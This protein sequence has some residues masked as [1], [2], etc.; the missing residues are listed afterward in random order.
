MSKQLR[1]VQKE[2]NDKVKFSLDVQFLNLILK[3]TQ[4]DYVQKSDIYKLKKFI[5]YTDPSLYTS[6]IEVSI[7]LE[8]LMNVTN[9]LIEDIQDIDLLKMRLEEK[10][11]PGVD[12]INKINLQKNMLN[13]SECNQIRKMIATRVQYIEVFQQK[14]HL[15]RLLMDIDKDYKNSTSFFDII[16]ELKTAMGQLLVALQDSDVTQGVMKEFSF[17]DE[18]AANILDNMITKA[19]KPSAILQTGI[20][21]LNAI[22]SPGFHSG[23]LYT[24]LGGSGKF[25]SGTLLNIADQIRLFNPQI[26]PVVNGIRKCILFITLENTIEETVERLYDMYSDLNSDLRDKSSKEI[27]DTLKNEGGFNI[28]KQGNGIDICFRYAGNLEIS[29]AEIYTIVNDARNKGLEPIAIVLDYI[30]RIDSAHPSNGDERTRM[31]FVS[32]ELKSIAQNFEIPVITAMQLNREGNSIIDAAVR[33]CKQD[34]ARFVGSSSIGNAW[35]IIE[36]SDWV[37]LINLELQKSTGRMYLTFKRLKIRGKKIPMA[38]EY[39]NHPFTNVKHIRLEPDVNLPA[40][41]SVVSLTNDLESIND[42]FVETSE[43]NLYPE[44]IG[45]KATN[46]ESLHNKKKDSRSILNTLQGSNPTAL[47]A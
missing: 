35:D 8:T 45:N 4:C 22:L 30:K 36:D 39:F 6:D 20:R 38:S 1:R 34:V 26:V 37:C 33:D 27:I 21:Q 41:I 16:Q 47:F 10:F 40:P 18:E 31:S 15:I 42:G 13:P 9:L 25:K 2:K 11:P 24:I 19:K 5:A 12:I 32:K 23:R 44:S 3:Y 29:T 17:S 43:S 14:D 28:G 7:L 46:L